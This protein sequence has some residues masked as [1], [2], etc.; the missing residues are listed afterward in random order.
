[1]GFVGEDSH[2]PSVL[3]TSPLRV[4][5]SCTDCITELKLVEKYLSEVSYSGTPKYYT[6]FL[7]DVQKYLVAGDADGGTKR[8]SHHE[9]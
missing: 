5:S 4:K 8:K 9:W 1:M 6:T 7:R 2:F 3:G